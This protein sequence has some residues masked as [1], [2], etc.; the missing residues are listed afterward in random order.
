VAGWLIA[1]QVHLKGEIHRY[2]E[3]TGDVVDLPDRPVGQDD[4]LD[5][6]VDGVHLDLAQVPGRELGGDPVDL[7]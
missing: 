4:P 3:T 2:W 5:A 6:L 7:E 1:K